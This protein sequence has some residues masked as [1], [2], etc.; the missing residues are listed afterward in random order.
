MDLAALV[1][2]RRV[3][4]WTAVATVDLRGTCIVG[5]RRFSC[6]R[7]PGFQCIGD[8]PISMRLTRTVIVGNRELIAGACSGGAGRIRR[9][10]Q[11]DRNAVGLGNRTAFWRID[12]MPRVIRGNFRLCDNRRRR[13]VHLMRGE[14]IGRIASE[15]HNSES[16]QSNHNDW[17][18]NR[19]LLRF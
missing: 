6:E 12:K 5:R 19:T 14:P 1:R 13:A 15:A 10:D 4:M 9:A 3:V 18:R 16:G 7:S 2:K 11:I 8:K 17:E